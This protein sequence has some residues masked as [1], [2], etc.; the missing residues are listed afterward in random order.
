MLT[1]NDQ[2]ALYTSKDDIEKL[3]QLI[4][5]VSDP[6]EGARRTAEFMAKRDKWLADHDKRS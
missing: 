1:V 6:V 4:A 5:M 3:N 2:G